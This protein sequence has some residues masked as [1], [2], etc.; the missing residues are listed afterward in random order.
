MVWVVCSVMT[1]RR[2]CACRTLCGLIRHPH[3]GWLCLR[4]GRGRELYDDLNDAEVRDMAALARRF[5]A[6]DADLEE[7]PTDTLKR[8]KVRAA[9]LRCA[10]LLR[11]SVI[12]SISDKRQ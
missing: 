3:P 8:I 7:L 6:G 9:R 4:S 12:I 11:A 2:R 1:Q 10:L 5:L